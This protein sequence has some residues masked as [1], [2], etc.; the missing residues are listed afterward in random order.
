MGMP[1]TLVNNQGREANVVA[2]SVTFTPAA[3]SHTGLDCVGG[4]AT[5]VIPNGKGRMLNLLGHNFSYATT[6]PI[7]T[8][9]TAFL[10]QST[11]T[12]IADD[13]PF[14]IA[15]ADGAL[16]LGYVPIPQAVDFTSTW[17]AI[18][19]ILA[20]PKTLGPLVTDTLTVYLQ[21]TTTATLEAVA[22]KLVM[23]FETQL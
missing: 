17:Q 8:V 9:W 14:V 23:F 19:T 21:L 3:S 6:T 15:S 13:A 5:V 20:Q 1:V 16:L 18:D 22:H 4:A 7:T 10:F 11:P 2:V 12:V